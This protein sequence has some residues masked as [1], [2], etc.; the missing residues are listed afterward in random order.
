[1][2]I[3][4]LRATL[5]QASLVSLGVGFLLGFVFTFNPVALASIPVSLAYVTKAREPRTAT[6]YGGMFILGMAIAQTL[7]GTVAAFGGQWAAQ[8][9]GREWGLVLGPVLILLGLVWPG[10]IKLPLP[11]I[12]VR[13][14]RVGSSWGAFVLGAVFAVAV[15]PFCT[16]ALIVLLGIAAAVGS[17]LFGGTLLLAFALGRAVPII[18]GAIAMGRLENLSTLQ[19]YRKAFEIAGAVTLV[20]AGL[21]MLN[22]FFLIIPEL[23]A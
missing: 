23:A 12:P 21:Y 8:M 7:L 16:P 14:R 6:L 20:L 2:D 1:M 15:C 3:E 10:W 4:S 13:A 19:R 18:L 17:P 9:I 11:A 5:Q 22:A